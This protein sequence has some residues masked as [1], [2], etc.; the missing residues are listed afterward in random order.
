MDYND[1]S[2]ILNNFTPSKKKVRIVFSKESV[3]LTKQEKLTKRFN[4]TC[5]ICFN[6]VSEEN[7]YL[8]T[9]RHSFCNT[10]IQE[11]F[12]ISTLCPICK[13]NLV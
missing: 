9:C 2:I 10:C 1:F 6:N 4:D 13:T 3:N 7:N 12:S 8:T 11:W 5:G